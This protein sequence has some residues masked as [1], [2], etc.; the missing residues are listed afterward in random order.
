MDGKKKAKKKGEEGLS[1]DNVTSE[2]ELTGHN[3]DN[4]NSSVE[5]DSFEHLDMESSDYQ[6]ESYSENVGKDKET[7]GNTGTTKVSIRLCILQNSPY[8]YRL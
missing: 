4:E 5:G 7:A 8:Q 1:S 2:F 6:P 3:S